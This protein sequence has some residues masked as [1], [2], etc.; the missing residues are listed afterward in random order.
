MPPA[1]AVLE[2]KDNFMMR[3]II[4]R[5]R[6]QGASRLPNDK[7]DFVLSRQCHDF[8][9]FTICSRFHHDVE[10]FIKRGVGDFPSPNLDFTK[11]LTVTSADVRTARTAALDLSSMRV[12][13]I[14]EGTLRSD[15]GFWRGEHN[16]RIMQSKCG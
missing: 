6:H 8:K 10:V 9:I 12:K 1:I 2:G 16:R 7:I 4:G 13:S 14:L 11:K 5:E 3:S 15:V